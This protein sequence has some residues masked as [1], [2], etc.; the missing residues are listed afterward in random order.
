MESEAL[1]SVSQR[2]LAS[3][4]EIDNVI[5]QLQA[6]VEDSLAK[7]LI[8]DETYSQLSNTLFE[9]TDSFS[10]YK[11]SIDEIE[12]KSPN[13]PKLNDED[14]T[15]TSDELSSIYTAQN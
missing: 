9:M 12:Y 6:C 4:R 13:F 8:D 2:V 14:F 11:A 7:G 5:T 10:S 3:M 15:P 1:V